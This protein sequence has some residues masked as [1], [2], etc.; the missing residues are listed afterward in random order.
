MPSISGIILAGGEGTRL[1]AYKPAVQL[2]G[3]PL[4][5]RPFRVLEGVSE[6]VLVAYGREEHR[7]KLEGLRL[8]ATLVPDEGPGPLGGLLVALKEVKGEWVV[9]APCDAP[10]LSTSLYEELLSR[11]QGVEGAVVRLR[12]VP[13][14][15]IAAYHTEALASAGLQVHARGD[16]AVMDVL[17][18]LSLSY[19][20]EE[21]LAR[22][23]YGL[24]CV[25][26]VDTPENL[27][28]AEELFRTG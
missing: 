23:P 5:L 12:G 19:L 6:E 11:G 20:E 7:E 4:I 17:A 9:V 8:E 21:D 2:A 26:D 1:G 24:N 3:E 27:A 28:R 25:L 14:P 16:D 15:V 10:L 18:L 13:N 22:M